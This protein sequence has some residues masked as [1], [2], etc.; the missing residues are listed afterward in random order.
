M[1]MADI[2][3]GRSPNARRR[4]RV[5]RQER[6]ASTRI[7]VVLLAISAQFALLPLASN[8]TETAMAASLSLTV[9]ER[10]VSFQ[11]SV[12]RRARLF[13]GQKVV[14]HATSH[15][16][17]IRSRNSRQKSEEGF[18]NLG[19]RRF[20]RQQNKHQCFDDRH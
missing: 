10:G 8:E 17:A 5:S 6:P 4:L 12:L 18:I 16:A 14:D 2:S 19:A 9:V 7:R 3:S 20:L 13:V 11:L 15:G 1:R